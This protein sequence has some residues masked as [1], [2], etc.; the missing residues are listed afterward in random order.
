MPLV[1]VKKKVEKARSKLGLDP[2]EEILGG[3]TTNPTGQFS[4]LLAWQ[5]G[6]VIGSLLAERGITQ[7]PAD[8]GLAAQ[9]PSGQS[10]VCL[11]DRRLIVTNVSTMTGSPKELLASYDKTDVVAIEVEKGLA[12]MPLNIAFADGSVVQVEGAKMSNPAG[13]A[14]LYANW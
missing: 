3:C 2:G 10:F 9:F 7:A 5:L 11:T 12:A 6:G 1:N 4:R 14:E 8:G 13:L